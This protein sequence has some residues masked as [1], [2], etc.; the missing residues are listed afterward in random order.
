MLS[1]QSECSGKVNCVM[2]HHKKPAC[3]FFGAKANVQISKGGQGSWNFILAYSS[4]SF[5]I[6]SRYIYVGIVS[7]FAILSLHILPS[8]STSLPSC[9][10]FLGDSSSSFLLA[11][12]V[13]RHLM[14]WCTTVS[15]L[16]PWWGAEPGLLTSTTPHSP[17]S[18]RAYSSSGELKYGVCIRSTCVYNRK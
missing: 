17:V 2:H 3:K 5:L 6:Q 4:N 14:A 8:T 1:H 13:R 11:S 15:S 12:C 7:V 9:L 18:H 16:T 10:C